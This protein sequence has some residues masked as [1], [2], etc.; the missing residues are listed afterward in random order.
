MN[1][2]LSFAFCRRLEFLPRWNAR[3][4]QTRKNH[5]EILRF[6]EGDDYMKNFEIIAATQPTTE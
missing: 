5:K 2:L 1:F 3:T 6:L 4:K